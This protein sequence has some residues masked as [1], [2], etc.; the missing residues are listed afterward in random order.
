MDEL[1]ERV[2]LS[3]REAGE[4]FDSSQAGQCVVLL[5]D[6]ERL[7]HCDAIGA[8]AVLELIGA[9][10]KVAAEPLEGLFT[11]PRSLLVVDLG[12]TSP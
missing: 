9:Q 6:T 3:R 1:R 11:Q 12:G 5:P 8:F 10:D 2:P 4:R 7:P